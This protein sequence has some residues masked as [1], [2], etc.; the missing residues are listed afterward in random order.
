[1][2]E[3]I[4]DTKPKRKKRSVKRIF[5]TVL[6]VILIIL[7]VGIAAGYWYIMDKLN[8]TEYVEIP[9]EEIEINEGVVE[10]LTNYRNIALLGIDSRNQDSYASGSRSDCIIIAS[11]NEDTS[12]VKLIS[13]YRDTYLKITG[14]SLDKVTH[15]YAYGGPALAISTLN[16][17]L[18]LN[19]TEFVAVNFE[20]V[21]DIVN[22]LDGININITSAELNYINE[23]IDETS[24]YTGIKSKHITKTGMQ[25]LD[26]VQ[27][28]AYA[29]IR[30]TSGGDY[31][32]TERMRTI[33]DACLAKAKTLSLTKLNSAANTILG[34]IETN[35]KSGEILALLPKVATYKITDSI[36]WP[37][38][39]KSAKIGGIYY[40]VPVTLE[41]CVEELHKELF[42]EEDYE[43]SET[44]E[45]IS[46][47][48]INK[49]G[50][51]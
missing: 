47:S 2:E 35:I 24:K 12:E 36:G 40:T 31:K 8:R 37:Y 4:T 6:L 48:I 27:A 42:G 19:I 20:A 10:Q 49:T 22:S 3:N 21:A 16:T 34:K 30:Y 23:Y 51:R 15:A 18:D 38:E 29:R 13:I 28:V 26:G 17:N 14:H 9:E 11:I 32:R 43:V 41:S 7:F 45:Q 50:Y 33:I 44:V 5:L 25:K 1:M 46:N 39:V